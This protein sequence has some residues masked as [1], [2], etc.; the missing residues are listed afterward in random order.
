MCYFSWKSTGNS[1]S[2]ENSM[3]N[4]PTLEP[5][6]GTSFAQLDLTCNRLVAS[7]ARGIHIS[8]ALFELE[9]LYMPS[10]HC[11]LGSGRDG[12]LVFLSFTALAIERKQY[13][14]HM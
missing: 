2:P 4:R 6:Q 13:L 14:S 7:I 10:L 1:K 11:I 3:K 9:C 12:Q 8:F 5:I